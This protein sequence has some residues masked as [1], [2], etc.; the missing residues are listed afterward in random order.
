MCAPTANAART[1][2]SSPRAQRKQTLPG[3]ASC[4]CGASCCLRGARIGDGGKRLIVD[5]DAL[6]GVRRLH[7]GSRRSPR[8]PARRHGARCRARAHSAAARPSACRRA[9]GS[10]QSGRIGAD[11]VGRHVGAGEHRDDAGRRLSPPPRRSRGCAHA[12]AASAR[13]RRQRARKLD[14]GDEAPAAARKRRSSTRRSG[15]P[16]PW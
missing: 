15:A 8:R 1:A 2:A 6:G 4:N 10:T 5:R 3:A 14:V 11:A 16:M 12:H 9:S 13:A 7:A